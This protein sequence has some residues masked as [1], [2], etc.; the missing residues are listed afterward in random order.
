MD[1]RNSSR[2]TGFNTR[3]EREGGGGG[4]VAS[5]L[6]DDARD[7]RVVLFRWRVISVRDESGLSRDWSSLGW[8]SRSSRDAKRP[9]ALLVKVCGA[10][11]DGIGTIP[12]GNWQRQSKTIYLSRSHD[13]SIKFKMKI[14]TPCSE[15]QFLWKLTKEK[16]IKISL[17]KRI[18]LLR[19][20]DWIKY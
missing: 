13:N 11:N 3:G 7:T 12:L 16:K 17:S 10:L 4:R 19:A 9:E 8:S 1:P 15:I 2:E 6:P 5:F 18:P 20:I 14:K